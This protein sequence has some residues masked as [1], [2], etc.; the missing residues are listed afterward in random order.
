MSSS[1]REERA[2]R[3]IAAALS[4][5]A[6]ERWLAIVQGAIAS[7]VWPAQVVSTQ[8]PPTRSR[9]APGRRARPRSRPMDLTR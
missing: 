9:P 1:P 3:A 2:R 4:T 6:P 8:P 7:L 5:M